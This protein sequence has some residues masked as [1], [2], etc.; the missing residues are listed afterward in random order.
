MIS[1][2]IN[3][4]WRRKN[5]VFLNTAMKSYISINSFTLYRLNKEGPFD[6]K[7]LNKELNDVSSIATLFI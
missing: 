4:I 3:Y 5:C 1:N 2:T 7:A 6:L